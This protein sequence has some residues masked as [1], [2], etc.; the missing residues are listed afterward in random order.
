LP[1]KPLQDCGIVIT[2]PRQQA[3][4][5]AEM[6]RQAGGEALLYPLL[7]IVGLDDYAAFDA[8]VAELDAYDWAIFI[9]SNAVQHGME[10][11]LSKRALP[12]KLR[13]ATIGPVTARELQAHG[14]EQ[15]LTPAERFDSESLLKMP[16][17][18]TVKGLRFVIF[19]GVGGRDVLAGKLIKRGAEVVFAESYRRITPPLA[20]TQL[21]GLWQN[22]RM[23]AIVVTS[24][25]ALR[26]LVSYVEKNPWLAEV[27]LFV[28]HARIS[29]NAAEH[30]LQARVAQQPGDE[31][32]LQALIAWRGNRGNP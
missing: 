5:L 22:G 10:R 9:S 14:V 31:G 23:H 4:V 2:R 19:R 1:N 18:R 27:P 25:E 21:H 13:W 11:L 28:N 24:S 7:E 26:Y 17:M 20:V 8:I 16:E 30:G 3:Q 15:V 29:E 6:V 32:M 12:S